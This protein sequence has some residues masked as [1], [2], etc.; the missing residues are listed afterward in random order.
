MIFQPPDS[1]LGLW[2]AGANVGGTGRP[3]IAG[4]AHTHSHTH[5]DENNV[6]SPSYP[7]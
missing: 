2:E 7:T 5:S 1:S 6:N 4:C 3:S